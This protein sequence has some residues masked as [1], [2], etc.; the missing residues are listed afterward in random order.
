[1]EPGPDVIAAT[2]AVGQ[3]STEATTA[4]ATPPTRSGTGAA[5]VQLDAGQAALVAGDIEL[6][7]RCLRDAVTEA[8]R[9]GGVE[10]QVEALVALGSSLINAVRSRD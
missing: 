5:R 1:M 9:C 10:T 6:G 2:E 4:A 8:H 3:A 7:L